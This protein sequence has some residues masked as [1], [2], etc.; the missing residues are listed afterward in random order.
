MN[1][2]VSSP[3]WVTIP[4]F[5]LL[6]A[7]AIE[8][9]VRLKISNVTCGLVFLGALL[10][11]AVH[12]FDWDL[13]QNVLVFL[14]VLAL[15]TAAFAAGWLGGGDV[16][17]LAALGLWFDVQAA[18]GLIA[19][20]F[21]AGGL[22]AIVSLSARK[23]GLRP[24]SDPRKARIPYGVAIAAGAFFILGTQLDNRPSNAYVDQI[25][26]LRAQNR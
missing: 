13:W 1:L 7:A 17:L 16:K 10:A 11:M 19:A 9:A 8:D 25:R 24:H 4:L 14:V 5:L 2:V 3:L 20:V 23:V 22:L 26:A 15:G 12:G 21:I 18:I 6:I